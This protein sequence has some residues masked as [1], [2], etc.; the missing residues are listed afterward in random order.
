MQVQDKLLDLTNLTN[1]DEERWVSR[2]GRLTHARKQ[3]PL[4]NSVNTISIHTHTHTHTHQQVGRVNTLSWSVLC[5]AQAELHCGGWFR[6][7]CAD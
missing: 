5:L 2:P 7:S 1:E 6:V 4:H 3:T